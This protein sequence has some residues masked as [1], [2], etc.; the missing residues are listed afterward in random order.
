MTSIVSS[1][2]TNKTH[3]A[4]LGHATQNLLPRFLQEVLFRYENPL[5]IYSTCKGNY[6][7]YKYF[8]KSAD[9]TKIN[10]AVTT[11]SFRNFD[12]PLIY[13]ILRNVHNTTLMPTRKWDN[14]IDP[15]PHKTNTGDDLERCRRTRNKIIHRGNTEVSDQE[16][17][18][19]FDEFRGIAGRLQVICNKKNNE[20]VTEFE[21]LR[22][23]CM[24]EETERKYLEDIEEWRQR[25]LEYED[26]ISQLK[27]HLAGKF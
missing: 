17:K 12:V 7:L 25:S 19:Y 9:W 14:K 26:Q 27:E 1:R 20:F 10:E 3:Y 24:D 5:H 8:L 11:A 15:L 22:T 16:L 13:T 6:Q 2:V 4:R 23:C 21:D 18:N